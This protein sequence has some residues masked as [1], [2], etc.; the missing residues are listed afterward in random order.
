MA[1]VIRTKKH[2]RPD[3]QS[4][5]VSVAVILRPMCNGTGA[6][7]SAWKGSADATTSRH[8]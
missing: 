6:A 7:K 2:L 3:V 1:Q 5:A 4:F 8:T